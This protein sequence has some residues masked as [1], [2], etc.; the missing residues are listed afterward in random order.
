MEIAFDFRDSQRVF[1]RKQEAGGGVRAKHPAPRL[2]E[3]ILRV[4]I[5]EQRGLIRTPLKR[6]R[7]L[8]EFNKR[9]FGITVPKV[10]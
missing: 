10:F 1:S 4:I 7:R 2:I 9:Q 3:R 8:M 5:L 6:T